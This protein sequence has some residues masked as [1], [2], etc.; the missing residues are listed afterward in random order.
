M[1]LRCRGAELLFIP[2]SRVY[3][4][5]IYI[6]VGYAILKILIFSSES[7]VSIF[8]LVVSRPSFE[9]WSR[10]L[11]NYCA[12]FFRFLKELLNIVEQERLL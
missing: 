12:T 10:I 4:L 2:L 5:F 6:S 7:E 1:A 3:V 8:N 9:A 11:A